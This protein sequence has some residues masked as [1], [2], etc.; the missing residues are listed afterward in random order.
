MAETEVE[1]ED[2]PDGISLKGFNW[3]YYRIS[4]EDVLRPQFDAQGFRGVTFRMGEA[5]SFGPLTRIVQCFDKDGNARKFIY[6]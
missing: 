2:L 4:E 6:G 5:D 3:K 1:Y